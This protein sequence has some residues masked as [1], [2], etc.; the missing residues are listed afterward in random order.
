MPACNTVT[1]RIAARSG[2]GDAG[3]EGAAVQGVRLQQL[4]GGCIGRSREVA[5]DEEGPRR[6]QFRVNR[7]SHRSTDPWDAK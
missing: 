4:W 5:G 6:Y 3:P 1:H 2:A 7:A